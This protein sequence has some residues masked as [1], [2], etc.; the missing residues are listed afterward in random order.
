MTA[1]FGPRWLKQ[2][3]DGKT[4]ERW[5]QRRQ[6]DIDNDR[7]PG[8]LLSYAG[9]EDYRSIIDRNDNWEKVFEPIFKVRASV[10]E[11]LRRLSLIRNPDAHFR[12]MTM[13]DLIELMAEERRV[14]RWL[15]RWTG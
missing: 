15:E 14:K 9:F 4:R 5:R 11:T 12:V 7:R 6:L 13:D 1:T 10:L 3:V 8:D 2:Q